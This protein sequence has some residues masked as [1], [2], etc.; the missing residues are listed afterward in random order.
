MSECLSELPV[1]LCLNK[2]NE[3]DDK[4]VR[5]TVLDMETDAGEK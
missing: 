4:I 2:V 3:L 5:T 1:Q